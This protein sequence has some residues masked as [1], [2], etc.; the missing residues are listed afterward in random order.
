M[1]KLLYQ[2]EVRSDSVYCEPKLELP[3]SSNVCKGSVLASTV[4]CSVKHFNVSVFSLVQ[5]SM[6]VYVNC[7]NLKTE[8]A[9]R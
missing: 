7:T 8:P 2:A 3:L 1:L 4:S 6:K 9:C 5:L